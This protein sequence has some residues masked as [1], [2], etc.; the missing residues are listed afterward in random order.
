MLFAMSKHNMNASIPTMFRSYKVSTNQGPGCTIWEALYATLAHPDLFKS[1][2]IGEGPMRESFV[3]GD[4]GCINP[5]AHV[6]AEVKRLYPDRHVS[7]ILSVGA[8][9]LRTIHIPNSSPYQRLLSTEAV[10][11]AKNLVTD[12]ERI[13][14][15]MAARFQ[16]TGIYHR[17]NVDQGMQN[18]GID[19][20]E[21]LG[22]VAAHTRAYI[23]KV[24]IGR[25]IDQA[26]QLIT[27]RKGVLAASLIGT[28]HFITLSVV[29]LRVLFY[30]DR[31]ENKSPFDPVYNHHQ[32]LSRAYFSVYWS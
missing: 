24:E 21:R 10:A 5:I 23:D 3:G 32:A 2:D 20:W 25:R 19:H 17:F 27:G 30:V 12:G 4:I 22:E 26:T 6:L 13:A 14:E 18:I 8:G 1:I 11:V 7:C 31:W 9:H 15:E 29:L 16:D 28:G